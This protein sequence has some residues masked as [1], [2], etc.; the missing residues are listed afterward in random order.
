MK[1]L[2]SVNRRLAAAFTLLEILI[3][4]TIIGALLAV[5]L[6]AVT[7]LSKSSA[8]KSAISGL[9]GI[10]EKARSQAIQDGQATY[11]VFPDKT[12]TSPTDPS[13]PQ[14]YCYRSYA[15]FEDDPVTPGT[16]KQITGWQSLPTG[17]SVRSGSLNYLAK[18]TSFPFTPLGGSTPQ[19][20]PFPSLKFN[21]TGQV[22]ATSTPTATTGTIQFGVFEGYVDSSG[23]EK[24]TS[25]TNFTESI[26][27][28]RLTGRAKRM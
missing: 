13:I 26:E 17:V 2:N 25:K 6:P 10:L 23:T 8:R 12:L 7:S 19:S 3:V 1:R 14:R 28:S 22:D 24:N 16:I 11:V 21:S 5:A 9:L 18:T 27:L 20:F 4:V 15:I